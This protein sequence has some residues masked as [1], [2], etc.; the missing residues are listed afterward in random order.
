MLP[1]AIFALCNAALLKPLNASFTVTLKLFDAISFAVCFGHYLPPKISV[2]HLLPRVRY[3]ARTVLSC[4]VAPCHSLFLP[5]IGIFAVALFADL[6]PAFL[7]GKAKGGQALAAFGGLTAAACFSVSLALYQY[8][9]CRIS[10]AKRRDR[11]FFCPCGFIF[12][13]IL[14]CILILKGTHYEIC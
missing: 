14:F 13:I 10:A 2:W 11:A 3:V 5:P 12:L 4:Y 9:R 6:R 7:Q 1:V 8:R